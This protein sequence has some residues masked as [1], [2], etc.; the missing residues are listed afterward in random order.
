MRVHH[1]QQMPREDREFGIELQLHARREEGEALQEPLHIGVGAV[2][3]V[4]AQPGGDLRIFAGELAAHLADVRQFLIVELQEARIHQRPPARSR[5]AIDICP[6]SRSSCVR[7]R[8]RSGSGCAHSSPSMSK[9]M[10]L[11]LIVAGSRSSF[12]FSVDGMIRGS[13]SWIAWARS[14]STSMRL[15]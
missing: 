2:E 10:A 3:C 1:L 11:W 15:R 6:A 5:S 9:V 8:M 4:E 14:R 13:K 12:T 7:R